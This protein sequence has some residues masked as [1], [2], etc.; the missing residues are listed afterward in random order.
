[1]GS[2]NS[3]RPDA[4]VLHIDDAGGPKYAGEIVAAQLEAERGTA[5]AITIAARPGAPDV[6]Q[7]VVS[8]KSDFGVASGVDYLTAFAKGAPIV[9]FGAGLVES[10]VAFF[11]R[12]NSNIHSPRDFVG[13]R[14]VRRPGSEAAI[15]YDAVLENLGISRSQVKEVADGDADALAAREIDVLPGTLGRDDDNLRQK[16][17]AYTALLPGDYGIHVPGTVYFA[18]PETLRDHPSLVQGVLQAMIA[19]WNAVYADAGKSIPVIASATGLPPEQVRFALNAQQA[20]V[21]PVSRRAGEFDNLQW[22]QLRI[23]LLSERMIKESVD[24]RGAV[25]YEFLREAYRKPVSFGNKE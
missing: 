9:A 23:I 7:R 8:G 11:V 5:P 25:N 2:P 6:F 4:V 15:V 20:A 12:E 3:T 16:G 19:G 22:E 13:K 17:I 1:V 24:M 14:V 18:K 21:R 10:P